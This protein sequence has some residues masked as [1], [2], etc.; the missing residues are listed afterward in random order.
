MILHIGNGWGT[1]PSILIFWGSYWR[2]VRRCLRERCSLCLSLHIPWLSRLKPRHQ[3]RREGHAQLRS[4]SGSHDGLDA[5]WVSG[6]LRA[7]Q[8]RGNGRRPTL[9]WSLDGD[10][11]K[12]K[13]HEPRDSHVYVFRTNNGIIGVA[14]LDFYPQLYLFTWK[15]PDSLMC[16]P[17]FLR[18]LCK[19]WDFQLTMRFNTESWFNG[20]DDEDD[21]GHSRVR[22]PP[23]G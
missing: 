23:C 8:T 20:L 14:K 2:C 11:W 5:W 16:I 19:M 18:K 22:V 4:T 21:G 7:T 6:V 1:E 12:F 17:C 15:Y 3:D 10:R 13:V 9:Q